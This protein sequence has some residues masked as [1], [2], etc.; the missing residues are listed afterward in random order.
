M[1]GNRSFS[2]RIACF[3]SAKVAT[4]NSYKT[5]P[6][7]WTHHPGNGGTSKAGDA[8]ANLQFKG[9]APKNTFRRVELSAFW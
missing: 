2:P 1:A 8:E 5:G 7:V 6:R 3:K 9:F 4:G